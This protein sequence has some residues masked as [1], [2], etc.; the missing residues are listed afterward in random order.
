MPQPPWRAGWPLLCWVEGWPPRRASQQ[1][2]MTTQPG[3][4]AWGACAP[5]RPTPASRHPITQ[6]SRYHGLGRGGHSPLAQARA[7]K[8]TR[9]VVVAILTVV[10]DLG[11]TAGGSG[12]GG[13]QAGG[14]SVCGVKHRLQHRGGVGARLISTPLLRGARA[15]GMQCADSPC[16][17]MYVGDGWIVA[18]TGL[19][20]P[21]H[22]GAQLLQSPTD[23]ADSRTSDP[24]RRLHP[25]TPC[26]LQQS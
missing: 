6:P 12:W 3:P 21:M 26:M 10:G 9:V 18:Q 1:Q 25:R 15:C 24:A 5:R 16:S 20:P 14:G 8:R 11:G 2:V 17:Q 7:I 13:Q 23:P 22:G 4:H 19:P